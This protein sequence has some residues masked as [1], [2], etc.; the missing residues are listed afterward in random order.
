MSTTVQPKASKTMPDPTEQ[1]DNASYLPELERECERL[2]LAL[3]LTDDPN[4]DLPE[5]KVIG[6][7]RTCIARADELGVAVDDLRAV[8]DQCLI[9]HGDVDHTDPATIYADGYNDIFGQPVRICP[10]CRNRQTAL[11]NE[12]GRLAFSQA[13][14]AIEAVFKASKNPEQTRQALRTFVD[15]TAAEARS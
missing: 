4:V 14:D 8:T 5:V 1:R 6:G 7:V 12:P 11:A 9:C 10:P 2:S 13:M 3:Q 15:M